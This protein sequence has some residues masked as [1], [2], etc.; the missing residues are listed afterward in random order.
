[1]RNRNLPKQEGPSKGG[2]HAEWYQRAVCFAG[3]PCRD[4][5]L[6]AGGIETFRLAAGALAAAPRTVPRIVAGPA[7]L[8]RCLPS[9]DLATVEAQVRA[10]RRAGVF[11]P[12]QPAPL[13][14]RDHLV[15][16]VIERAGKIGRHDDE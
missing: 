3:S 6:R 16:E 14:L 13:Q 12:V 1:M 15:D 8:R 10:Q 11:I 4:L 5:D 9:Y 2:R 7:R